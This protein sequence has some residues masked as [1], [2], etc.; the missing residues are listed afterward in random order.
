MPKVS[1]IIPAYNAMAYLP[2]TITSLLQQ[3]FSDFEVIIINDGSFD[4]IEEWFSQIKDPRARLITQKNLGLSA[5]RNTGISQAQGKYIA[6]LDADDLWHST[7]LEK[8][9]EVLDTQ[10]DIGLVYCW[11]A[12]ID[13]NSKP[14]GRIFKSYAQGNVWESLTE[15]NLIRCGSVPMVRHQCFQTCGGF[16]IN[17]NAAQDWD[18]WLRIAA[19]YSFAL[20]KEPLVYYRQHPNNK[21]KVY[22]QRT[23]DFRNL[24]EKAF[25]SAPFELLYLRNRSYARI[26]LILAWKCIQG[27]NKDYKQAEYFLNQALNHYPQMRFSK[28]YFRLSIAI[29][30]MRWF[31]PDGYQKFVELVYALRRRT[32]VIEK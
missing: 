4:N 15:N 1:V 5:A 26:N 9:V 22:T 8:Q 16:D 23:E 13:E 3:T 27:I 28:E 19:S 32:A 10:Q 30:M 25:E 31:G 11:T 24:I 20:I 6:F 2:E 18:M 21:S 29:T 14:T 12:L 7:K 17:I